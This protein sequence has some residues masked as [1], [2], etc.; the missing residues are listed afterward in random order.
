MVGYIAIGSSGV[1]LGI[2]LLPGDQVAKV[3]AAKYFIHYNFDMEDHVLV[4][5][6]VNRAVFSHQLAQQNQSAT[7]KLYITFGAS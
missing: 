4:Q 5:M 3:L 1:I 7:Q 2:T 6:D